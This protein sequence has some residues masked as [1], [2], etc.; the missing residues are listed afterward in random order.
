MK[1][2]DEVILEI[3]LYA[4]KEYNEEMKYALQI[5]GN[6]ESCVGMC[7]FIKQGLNAYGVYIA[8]Y[9]EIRYYIPEF[10]P[11][12]L[13]GI[14]GEYWWHLEDFQSRI[15][16][17]DKLIKIY[18]DKIENKKNKQSFIQKLL[19]SIKNLFNG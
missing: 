17:F 3:L 9:T 1:L 18:K 8:H 14:R 15:N 16:A 7:Y 10:Y 11:E 4:R 19:L 2:K 6:M 5:W 12:N 13:G